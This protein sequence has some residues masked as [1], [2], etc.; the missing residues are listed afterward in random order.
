[1]IFMFIEAVI[2]GL[3]IGSIRKGRI[4][5]LSEIYIKGWLLIIIGALL[6]VA[7]VILYKMN[8]LTEVASYLPF[9][10]VVIMLIVILMNMN[11]SGFW[12]LLI[13]TVMNLIAMGFNGFKMPV[14][15]ESLYKSGL[16]EMAETVLDGSIINYINMDLVDNFTKYFGK[17]IAL[18]DFY[19]FAKVLSIGDIVLTI[20]IILFIQGEMMN[21]YYRKGSM[22]K[23]NYNTR[24]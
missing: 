6:Q 9:I 15:I 22:V 21:R 19:P 23:Y 7:P 2:I 1:M 20:G 16:G 13:G 3:I 17:F 5:N 11:L 18:P 14:S 8:I 24:Y 10:S 12:L 4:S